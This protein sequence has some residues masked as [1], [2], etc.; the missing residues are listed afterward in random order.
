M[1]A[2]ERTTR[3]SRLAVGLSG[4]IQAQPQARAP[5][6][7]TRRAT[8]WRRPRRSPWARKPM[9]RIW[10][11]TAW[12]AEDRREMAWSVRIEPK[13]RDMTKAASVRL[14]G[15]SQDWRLPGVSGR[16]VGMRSR[17]VRARRASLRRQ[18]KLVA[19]E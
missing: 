2:E 7:P 19:R 13:A 14:V 18:R 8:I 5:M 15:M 1:S 10:A 4:E 9:A 6:T 17:L 12:A 16:A 3:R 11:R